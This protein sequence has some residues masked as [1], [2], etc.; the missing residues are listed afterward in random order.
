MGRELELIGRIAA[1]VSDHPSV[2]EGIGDDA[3]VLDAPPRQHL[4]VTADTLVEGVHFEL[5]AGTGWPRTGH[6][7]ADVGVK[8][9]AVNLSDMAAMGAVPRWA[10]LSVAVPRRIEIEFISRFAEALS[11]TLESYGCLLAGGDTVSSPGPL[12][13]TLTVVGTT[14]GGKWLSR[15]GARPGDLVLCSGWLGESAAGLQLIRT[16]RLARLVPPAVRRRLEA[17]HLRPEPRLM[18]G[19]ALLRE[20]LATSCID[21]SDGPATDLAHLA[22]RSGVKIV[23]HRGRLPVSRALAV[24]ARVFGS[25]PLEWILSGGEDFELLWTAPRDMAARS[26][27]LAGSILGRKAAIIGEVAEG[28]GVFLSHAGREVEISFQGYEH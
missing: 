21:A 3:A 1:L 23:L 10:F 2:V 15:N 5:Q 7:A 4:V 22:Q 16:P 11:R 25:T 6:S 26:A 24:A 18:L 27:A 17:R 9:A 14:D 20:G 8:A 12:V 28:S 19:R 13:V